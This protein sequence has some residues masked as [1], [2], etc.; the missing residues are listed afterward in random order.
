MKKLQRLWHNEITLWF[1]HESEGVLKRLKIRAAYVIYIP[2]ALITM[3]FLSSLFLSSFFG[4]QVNQDELE[5]LRAENKQLAERYEKLRYSVTD[6]KGKVNRLAEKEVAIRA[7]FNLPEVDPQER[8]LGIGGPNPLEWLP[9]NEGEQ[10][11]VAT[12]SELDRLLK[13]TE[14]EFS[15]YE[16]IEEALATLKERLEHTPSIWPVK[17]WFS[18][19]YGMHFDPFTGYQQM[20]RGIDIANR[21]GTAIVAPAKG[22]VSFVGYDRGGMGNM[23]VIDHGYGFVTRHGH[24]SKTLVKRG[25]E[26]SRGDLLGLMGST[27]YSTG[28]H[29]HYEVWRNGKPLNPM[30]FILN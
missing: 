30:D 8:M 14:Y 24:L 7:L 4:G 29:L 20:H 17:G 26:V 12:E 23:V 22:K 15:K 16:E 11:A 2:A 13:Q 6:I 25:Q 3:L 5:R 21:Q 27:G 18:R 9:L 1:L 10:M 19:G 28:S